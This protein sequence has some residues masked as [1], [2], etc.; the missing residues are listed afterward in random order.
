MPPSASN[1]SCFSEKNLYE[2]KKEYQIELVNLFD[3][4]HFDYLK[5]ILQI[6]PAIEVSDFEKFEEKYSQGT[7]EEKRAIEQYARWWRV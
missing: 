5:K 3:A 7:L 6:E 2:I 1:C 4:Q